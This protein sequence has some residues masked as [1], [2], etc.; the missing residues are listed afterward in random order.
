MV[1]DNVSATNK[2]F[3]RILLYSYDKEHGL[4]FFKEPVS[5]CNLYAKSN[6]DKLAAL[7]IQLK[8]MTR[9]NV[10]CDAII[11]RQNNFFMIRDTSIRTL[12]SD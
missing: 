6:A 1:K 8:N 5:P 12:A 3:F 11:E 2:N 9:F 10:W 4:N 7:E